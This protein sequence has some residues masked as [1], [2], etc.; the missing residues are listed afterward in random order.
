M[1]CPI[2]VASIM[3][4]ES[5]DNACKKRQFLSYIGMQIKY[6]FR[7]LSHIIDR[8]IQLT[9]TSVRSGRKPLRY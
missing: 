4:L 7:V 8:P 2:K 1:F 6:D 3:Y 9:S 5:I